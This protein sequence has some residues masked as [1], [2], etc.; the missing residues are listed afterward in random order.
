MNDMIKNACD[1]ATRTFNNGLHCAETVACCVL[2]AAGQDATM[3]IRHA[4]PFGGGFGVSYCEA[5]GALSGGLI[6][7]GHLHGRRENGSDWETPK[8]MAKALRDRFIEDHGTTH[9]QT[10]RDRFGEQQDAECRKIVSGVTR[11]LLEMIRDESAG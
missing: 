1:E 5:C 4:T 11:S 8:Q 10:L 9:C 3:A 2:H 6:A 7:I